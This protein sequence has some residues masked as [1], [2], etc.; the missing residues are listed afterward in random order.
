MK[1]SQIIE[2]QE[3]QR[4]SGRYQSHVIQILI[5][6]SK[7][8]SHRH[9]AF[10][11]IQLY[12]KVRNF[13]RYIC[14]Y[15]YWS[16]QASLDDPSVQ[17]EWQIDRSYQALLA[18]LEMIEKEDKLIFLKN[19]EIDKSEQQNFLR[20]QCGRNKHINKLIKDYVE[21]SQI[22]QEEQ[23]SVKRRLLLNDDRFTYVKEIIK[24]LLELKSIKL[25]Q[26]ITP[27]F[28][29]NFYTDLGELAFDLYTKKSYLNIL[30]QL[31][32]QTILDIGCGNGNYLSLFS[33]IFPNA[34]IIG[35]ERQTGICE[36]L[37]KKYSAQK[38]IQIVNEDITHLNLN[39]TLDLVNIS[40]MLFYLDQASQVHLF[41]QLH[42]LLDENGYI[43]VCQYYPHF[44]SEQEII[45]RYRKDWTRVNRFKYAVA[46]DILY[47]EVLLNDSIH[48]FHQAERFV[49]FKALLSQEGFLI[50]QIVPAD[51]TYYSYFLMIKKGSQ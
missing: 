5:T 34:W 12:S 48:H 1:Y 41:R 33:E 26:K 35:V 32:C 19:Y 43:I 47:A 31:S 36:K 45:S 44:E 10:Y 6:F 3:K 28:S 25:T 18:K 11:E 51:D 50:D 20:E 42:Q 30:K 40:Y 7:F 49:D 38:N 37:E 23:L 46:N 15:I 8:L 14:L 27:S 17:L 4:K 22:V 29:E 24:Y 9:P 21:V 16:N 13:L 2:H 39:Q